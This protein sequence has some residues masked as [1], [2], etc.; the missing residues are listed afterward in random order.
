MRPGAVFIGYDP[1]REV[2]VEKFVVVICLVLL[3]VIVGSRGNRV[4]W[5]GKEKPRR[6]IG[7][8][9]RI[10]SHED[11]KALPFAS[12]EGTVDRFDEAS[13]SYELELDASGDSLPRSMKFVKVRP[14]NPGETL[15][16]IRI[17]A[18]RPMSVDIE[19]PG[20]GWQPAAAALVAYPPGD[21]LRRWA[22]PVTCMIIGIGL[23]VHG[24]MSLWRDAL[25]QKSGRP[26]DAHVVGLMPDG[27][28]VCY[29]IRVDANARSYGPH[30]FGGGGCVGVSPETYQV[31]GSQKY[32]PALY[33][34]KYPRFNRLEPVTARDYWGDSF[35]LLIGLGLLGGARLRGTSARPG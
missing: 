17:G 18:R 2:S 26:I 13:N 24:S 8:R 15:S 12:L 30:W 21:H 23:L 28:R 6:L 25:V 7:A 14:A 29:E 32:I 3:L 31:I 34:P 5:G 10:E 22:G 9:L 4:L 16:S 19:L 11:R 27:H 35:I 20:S 1:A 33:Y